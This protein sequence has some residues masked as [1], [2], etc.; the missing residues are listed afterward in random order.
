MIKWSELSERER[1]AV[2]AVE[3]FSWQ[4]VEQYGRTII[5]P[6]LD[7][8]RITWTGIWDVN[9]I[10]QYMP[11]YTTEFSVA[12]TAIE[13]IQGEIFMYRHPYPNG[14]YVI[15]LGYSGN[16]C[17]ECGEEEFH[18]QHQGR[19]TSAPQAICLAALKAYGIEVE[20]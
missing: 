5:I 10:P 18:V 4:K 8:E 13:K 14:E 11:H 2:V 12:W 7:D 6:P 15:S 3:L 9:G 20:L 16:E 1:D 19:S 17:S